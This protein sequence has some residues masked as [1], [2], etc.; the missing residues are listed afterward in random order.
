M[1]YSELQAPGLERYEE[2][3]YGD[4]AKSSTNDQSSW[5]FDG[6]QRLSIMIR[7]RLS[8]D[9]VVDSITVLQVPANTML[10]YLIHSQLL[11]QTSIHPHPLSSCPQ[12]FKPK[13]S[14]RDFRV[15]V[16]CHQ[17]FH[18]MLAPLQHLPLMFPSRI[19]PEQTN[20][21]CSHT[22]PAESI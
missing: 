6:I 10:A 17:R 22:F 18:I 4:L 9:A 20:R 5:R 21:Q 1:R 13:V 8:S 3:M 2:L 16:S 19:Y 11:E 14:N 12:T 7:T 15:T